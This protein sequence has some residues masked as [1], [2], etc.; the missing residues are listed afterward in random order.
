MKDIRDLSITISAGSI[1]MV[2]LFLAGAALLFYLRDLVLIVL[3]AIVLA[4]AIEPAVQFFMKY[5]IN[6]IL[7][8]ASVYLLTILSVA[9]VGFIF[10]PPIIDDAATFISSLPQTI[11][12]LEFTGGMGSSFAQSSIGTL[13]PSQI[14][15]GIRSTFSTFTGG[16]FST[17]SAFFGGVLSLLLIIV[18]SFYFS[19]QETGIDDFLRIVTPVKHQ[20][21]VLSLWKRSQE[22]IGK[23]MQGQILLALLVGVL[24]W[25]G[26]VILAVPHALFLAVL[27][28]A[29]ELIPVFGQFIAAI[30]A[31]AVAFVDGGITAGVLVAGLYLIVQQ[32]ESNLIYPL[33]V[34]KVVGVPPILVILALLI[35]GSLAGFLGVLLS[36][37]IAAALQ[38]FV[39]D[40]Q[41]KKERDLARLNTETA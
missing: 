38:E 14:A 18:F 16:L 25:L 35:G 5:R 1:L 20:E 12:A 3:T 28:A 31:I 36:V 19:V 21:Y 15:E 11:Q 7:S 4:S 23:W 39:N 17:V 41:K 34:K 37:P 24:L 40:I 32:F 30:P 13:S 27:A 10:I 9:A 29:F 22:K 2:L 8:V 33:V 26:L 6:R